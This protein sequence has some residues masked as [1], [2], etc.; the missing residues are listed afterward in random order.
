MPLLNLAWKTSFF[1]DGRASSLRAQAL[2]PIQDHTEMDQ[3]LT[4]L[5]AKLAATGGT[6]WPVARGR[7]RPGSG[8]GGPM[9]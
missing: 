9:D 7:R 2:M 1:W 5:V 4:N 3:S 6:T 8:A